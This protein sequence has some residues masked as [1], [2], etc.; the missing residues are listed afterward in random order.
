MTRSTTPTTDRGS[1]A[2][3]ASRGAPTQNVRIVVKGRKNRSIFVSGLALYKPGDGVCPTPQRKWMRRRER[4]YESQAACIGARAVYRGR[5]RDSDFLPC[6]SKLDA[7]VR[8]GR[9]LT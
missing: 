7:V 8:H 5:Q 2:D 4:S 6:F 1:D 9:R 3:A